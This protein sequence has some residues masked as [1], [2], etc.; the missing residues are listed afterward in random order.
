VTASRFGSVADRRPAFSVVIC[1]YNRADVLPRAI[2]T[3]LAQDFD[4]F[5]LVVVDDGSKDGTADAVGAIADPRVHYVRQENAGLG[6][7][8]NTGVDH[9]S[10][11]YVVFLDDDDLA[12][13]GWLAGL[14]AVA[15][16]ED[17]TVVCCG[18]ELA[19]DDGRLL[20]TNLP[21]PMGSPYADV[22]GLFVPGTFAVRPDAYQAAGGF[23]VGL[24]HLHH[25]EFALRLLPLCASRGW[26]VCTVDRALVRR[27]VHEPEHGR[28]RVDHMLSATSYI[29][30]HHEDRLS[31]LPSLLA[32]YCAIAGVAA[33]RTGDVRRARGYFRRAMRAN[34]RSWKHRV[35]WALT[36]VPPAASL[37]W[38]G[39]RYRM[40]LPVGP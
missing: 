39:R 29:V 20:A 30:E 5:E 36:L 23:V 33:V 12:L 3:V 7:A 15:V 9:A 22:V 6:A 10:G 35:R 8:R 34:P 4:D 21:A 14:H 1:T 31:L 38:S 16:D 37:V 13:P 18:E 27:H 25:S 26:R 17:C 40:T 32:Q 11:R 28:H 19:A 2:D 24:Q